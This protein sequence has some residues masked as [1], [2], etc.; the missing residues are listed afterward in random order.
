MVVDEL[1]LVEVELEVDV[2]VEVLVEVDE[3]VEVELEVDD[4]L[5]DELVVVNVTSDC[6]A[7]ISGIF[8]KQIQTLASVCL[9]QC[10]KLR[11]WLLLLIPAAK[12]IGRPST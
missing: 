5:V 6:N 1:E 10:L 12:V 2:E 3:D 7:P 11:R 4:E 8:F 9:R